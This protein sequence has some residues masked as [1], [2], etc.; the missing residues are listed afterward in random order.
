[1]TL[2]HDQTALAVAFEAAGITSPVR[3]STQLSKLS[4]I[5]PAPAI[6]INPEAERQRIQLEKNEA[7]RIGNFLA[8]DVS[9]IQKIESIPEWHDDAHLRASHAQLSA[10]LQEV[11]A[12][13]KK[14]L[15]KLSESQRGRLKFAMQLANIRSMTYNG[16]DAVLDEL[17]KDPALEKDGEKIPRYGRMGHDEFTTYCTKCGKIPVGAVAWRKDFYVPTFICPEPSGQV[18]IKNEFANRLWALQ[19]EEVVRF[20]NE[21][22]ALLAKWSGVKLI[23]GK[24][25]SFHEGLFAIR[26]HQE[27][28]QR[29]LVTAMP[30]V[31][32]V[33]VMKGDHTIIALRASTGSLYARK[34]GILEVAY[35]DIFSKYPPLPKG[36]ETDASWFIHLL[37][38]YTAR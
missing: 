30:G 5:T 6:T 4:D 32:I 37:R 14:L 17:V 36:R 21:I 15:P 28:F 3:Q 23:S 26:V 20:N 8:N 33:Q 34:T 11:R 7:E 27:Y 1:M 13:I 31:L 22:D 25:T 35:R 38:K 12:G 2:S 18:R 9:E 19:N 10:H 29:T 16:V 24:L